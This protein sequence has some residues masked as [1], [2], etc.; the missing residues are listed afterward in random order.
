M[1]RLRLKPKAKRDLQKIFEYTYITWGIE[2]AEKYQ[3]DL[4]YGM[5]LILDQPEIGKIYHYSNVGYR[6]MHVN[7]HLIFYRIEN[8]TCIIVRVLH[9]VM[10]IKNHL[11]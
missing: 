4:F 9:D 10:D 7:R 8:M 1:L 2:Q 5:Q 6:K 11:Q 3:D